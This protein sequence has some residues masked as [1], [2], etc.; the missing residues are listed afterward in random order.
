MI[1]VLEG[2]SGYFFGLQPSHGFLLLVV[3]LV[4]DSAGFSSSAFMS[5]DSSLDDMMNNIS[6]GTSI[7]SNSV[8]VKRFNYITLRAQIW[9]PLGVGQSSM[10][11]VFQLVGVLPLRTFSGTMSSVDH[12]V[13]DFLEV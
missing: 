10:D 9:V 13:Q 7:S 8:P 1:A 3:D 2:F 5:L 12:A 4:L 11:V 6:D